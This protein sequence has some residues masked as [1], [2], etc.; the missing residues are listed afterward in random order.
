VAA[1]IKNKKILRDLAA[2]LWEYFEV[3]GQEKPPAEVVLKRMR[4]CLKSARR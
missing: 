4:E 2:G 3:E 1:V